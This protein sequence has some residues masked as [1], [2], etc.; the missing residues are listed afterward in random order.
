[1]NLQQ[2]LSENGVLTHPWSH[3]NGTKTVEDLEAEL[4]AGEATLKIINN[5]LARVVTVVK[6]V[7]NI[8]FGD[9]RFTLVEDK[10]IFYTGAVRKRGLRNLAEKVK[11]DETPETATRRALQEEIGLDLEG[12][13]IFEGEEIEERIS[14]SYPGLNSVYNML[15]YRVI[16][17]RADLANLRFSEVQ[18]E[19]ISLFTLEPE[20]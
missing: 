10:Q 18:P 2:I 15:A 5:Q 3:T 16:L 13:L 6:I 17:T 8:Q 19:K 1:M 7:V 4:Q 9:K 14:P 20:D 12:E 11:P